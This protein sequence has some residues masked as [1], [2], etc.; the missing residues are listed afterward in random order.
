MERAGQPG[1]ARTS[2]SLLA[3]LLGLGLLMGLL[4]GF[5]PAFYLSSWAPLS[6]L[7]GKHAAGKGNLRLREALVLVQFT[8]SVAVIAC[9]ILMAAQMRY[10]ASKSLGLPEGESGG[11]DVARRRDHRR[12]QHDPHGTGQEQPHPGHNRGPVMLG[13]NT[14]PSMSCHGKQ[15]KAGPLRRDCRTCRSV[16]ISFESW[17]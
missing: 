17:D 6:A 15:E 9:T 7:T 16:R 13:Q 1:S 14:A 2:P 10:I 4:S 12:I 3:A 11:R 5:Y 8:I